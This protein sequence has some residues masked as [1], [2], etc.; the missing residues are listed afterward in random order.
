MMKF[1]RVPPLA[2]LIVSVILASAP[3]RAGGLGEQFFGSFD[4][5]GCHAMEQS[6][7]RA[8]GPNL[9][10]LTKRCVGADKGYRYSSKFRKAMK[11]HNG[12]KAW[13]ADLLLIYL[14]KH[15]PQ[16]WP[17]RHYADYLREKYIGDG[18]FEHLD[19]LPADGIAVCAKNAG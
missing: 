12:S 9:Y 19:S 11:K 15:H 3:V 2:V 17:Q 7:K 8:K 4:C 1:S 18:L 13:D 10:G 14:R 6:G 5:A 16:Q